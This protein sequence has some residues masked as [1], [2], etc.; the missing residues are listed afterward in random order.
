LP[1]K[2][3]LE[4]PVRVVREACDDDELC[5]VGV[6]DSVMRE[7]EKALM[8]RVRQWGP[9]WKDVWFPRYA[10]RIE[11]DSDELYCLRDMYEE[12]KRDYSD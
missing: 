2:V 1:R 5:F 10:I 3:T 8:I 12:K 4:Y 7:S 9:Q 6:V 11:E